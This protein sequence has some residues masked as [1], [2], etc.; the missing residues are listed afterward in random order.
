MTK[1]MEKTPKTMLIIARVRPS[2]FN[3]PLSTA[4]RIA[5]K[6]DIF[7]AVNAA[8]YVGQASIYGLAR[9]E[10]AL[11][12]CSARMTNDEEHVL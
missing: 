10:K 4:S 1:A 6:G 8:T 2:G 11:N 5:S 12:A 9:T 7:M 3:S